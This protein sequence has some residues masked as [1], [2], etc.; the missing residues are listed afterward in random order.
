M[1]RA[2]LF[3]ASKLVN[4][5]TS[6][7]QHDFRCGN[8]MFSD[9]VWDF[10]GIIDVPHWNDAQYQ[11]DFEVFSSPI[12][13]E[14]V[15]LY[16]V[17]ELQ[18][19]AFSSVK[20]KL[21]A[22]KMLRNYLKITPEMTSFADFT[23]HSLRGFFRYIL[24][25]KKEDEKPLSAVSK[26]I[27]AQVVKELLIRGGTRGWNVPKDTSYINGLYQTIITDNKK[28]KEG[29]K[30]GSTNKVLPESEIIDKLIKLS[31]DAL[32]NDTDILAAASILIMSQVGCRISETLSI[33]SGCLSPI[34]DEVF[35][36]Y[37]TS[38]TGKEPVEVTRPA[39]EL[40]V[41]TIEKLEKYTSMLRKESGFSNLFLT[42]NRVKKGRPVCLASSSNWTKNRL[43]P[44]IK[45]HDL[46]DE[47]G[48]LLQLTSHYFRHIFATYAFKS[49][50]KVYDVAEMMNHK[51]ILMTETY[52]HTKEQKQQIITGILSGEIPVSSTNR[53][54][55]QSIEGC[56]NPFK[57]LT[58]DQVDKMR[59]AMKIEILPHGIC[60][61]HPMRGEPCEQDGVCLG[62]NNFLASAS[63]LPIY[64]R[65]LEKINVEIGSQLNDK[66]IYN[67]KLHY[68]KGKL[69][70][71]I[72]ELK[73]KLSRK[74]FQ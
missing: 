35:I 50:M 69:E 70:N 74:D 73:S 2:D 44:F 27:A 15:K 25:A 66:S 11:L 49:G 36:T 13:R 41:T 48:D 22:F 53:I 54:A 20:R 38:K 5:D 1:A 67:T 72:Q 12:I 18:M 16:I 71:Y 68:Q 4:Y 37:T 60:L 33:K 7:L 34:D 43:M 14:T 28:I 61:H 21:Y 10:K 40:I 55:L 30:L 52:D 24:N 6:N 32:G 56:E 42:R 31:L 19:N 3:L 23:K 39:N 47:S 57:G 17:T 63:Y 8:N 29:T 59:R 26:K 9:N 62:C 58:V 65:R 51:S 64:E 45:K 46:R